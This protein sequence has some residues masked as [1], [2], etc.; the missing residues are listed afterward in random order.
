MTTITKVENRPCQPIR[1]RYAKCDYCNLEILKPDQRE[2]QLKDW[3]KISIKKVSYT[4]IYQNKVISYIKT[5]MCPV[6][7]KR[8]IK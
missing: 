3:A 6:C 7:I 5:D 8:K 2:T 1:R 4:K